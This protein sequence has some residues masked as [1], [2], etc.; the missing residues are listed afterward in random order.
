MAGLQ[1]KENL[2]VI[3]GG[4]AGEEIG[5]TGIT[6]DWTDVSSL[7]GSDTVTYYFRDSDSGTNANSSRVDITVTETWSAVFNADRSYTVTVRSVVNS[8]VRGN[9]QGNPGT[10]TRKITIKDSVGGSIK[11]SVES[12]AVNNAH[13]LATNIDLGITTFTLQPNSGSVERSAIYLKSGYPSHFNDPVPNQYVDEMWIGIGFRNTLPPDYRPMKIRSS[14]GT[15]MSCNRSGGKL[16]IRTA[17]GTMKELRTVDG[18]TGTGNP[19]YIRHS[20]GWKN[21]RLIGQQ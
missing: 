7:S 21:Q 20:D 11:W 18:G 19:P 2:T 12:D 1:F 9:I 5:S 6:Q 4:Y 16:N 14:D 13:T 3:S 15:W 8:I 10:G 17:N